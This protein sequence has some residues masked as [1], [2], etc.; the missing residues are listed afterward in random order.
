MFLANYEHRPSSS[1]E[2]KFS[3]GRDLVKASL[4]WRWIFGAISTLEPLEYS[5]AYHGQRKSHT[6]ICQVIVLLLIQ[7]GTQSFQFICLTSFQNIH[8][9]KIYIKSCFNY[10]PPK[11]RR[12]D[13]IHTC[14]FPWFKL[15]NGGVAA[16]SRRVRGS[17]CLGSTDP[18][19]LLMLVPCT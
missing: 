4:E 17:Y 11:R 8:S 19:A 6:G 9:W 14:T 5:C 3:Q 1:L 13:C 7:A 18:K 10:F 2:Q 15:R 12:M 16:E